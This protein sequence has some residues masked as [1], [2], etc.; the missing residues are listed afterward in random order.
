MTGFLKRRWIP[1]VITMVLVL[2]SY[3]ALKL[4]GGFNG[5]AAVGGGEVEAIR[6]IN[7]KKVV[8]EIDGPADAKGY[9]DY[10]DADAQPH[11]VPFSSLP[12][13]Y[14]ITTTLASVFASVVAQ[15]NGNSISC[16]IMVNGEL[17][18]HQSSRELNPQT[19]CLVKA[20]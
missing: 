15:S 13:S 4:H 11:G 8:Y 14:T 12:W 7:E 6:P 2:G 20:A 19:Y 9:V 1:L 3:M 10:L 5:N 18:E 16:R 17:V